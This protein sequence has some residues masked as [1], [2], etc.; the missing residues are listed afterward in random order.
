MKKPRK[1]P[2]LPAR[3]SNN[4]KRRLIANPAPDYIEELRRNITYQG[5]SKHKQHPH[6]YGLTSFQGDRGDATLCDRDA[7]FQPSDLNSIPQMIQRGLRAGLVGE[8]GVI[9]AVADNGWIYEARITNVEKTEYH[10]YPV[11]ATEPIAEVVYGR[12]KEWV[13]RHGNQSARRAVQ[14]CKMLY[15][16]R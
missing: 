4:D 6:L 5:S 8:S 3:R 14:Q 11:L 7:N 13:Q 12:F 16:F 10:G 15:G 9:W 2:V 1:R